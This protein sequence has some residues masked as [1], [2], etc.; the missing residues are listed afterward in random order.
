[1]AEM[2]DTMNTTAD[3]AENAVKAAEEAERTDPVVAQ[4]V[5]SGQL[6]D[7]DAMIMANGE[8]EARQTQSL[9]ECVSSYEN[10]LQQMQKLY[11]Q[12]CGLLDQMRSIS[13]ENSRRMQQLTQTAADDTAKTRQ[14]VE[15]VSGRVVDTLTAA[16]NTIRRNADTQQ[17]IADLA[18]KTQELEKSLNGL[19]SHIDSLQQGMSDLIQQ[20]DDFAHKEHVRVYRN[21]QAATEQ[22]LQKYTD[23]LK[24]ELEAVKTAA[25]PKVNAVQILTLIFAILAAAAGILNVT[26]L[27]S[28]LMNMLNF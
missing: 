21:I 27:S 16:D 14:S 2:K 12:N 7:A 8:A 1:M 5:G 13:D 25:R 17:Q 18:R 9:K 15:E 3:Q 11:H 6:Q 24:Q 26:G 28:V 20:S 23:E 4:T 19:S 10:Q 22:S